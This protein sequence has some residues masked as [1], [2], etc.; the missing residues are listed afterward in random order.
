MRVRVADGP[1]VVYLPQQAP[2]VIGRDTE[3]GIAVS[4]PLVSRRHARLVFDGSWVIEDVGSTNG[5][6]CGGERLDRHVVAGTVTVGLG[7]PVG[8]ARLTLRVERP[9]AA[10]P[11]L[12]GGGTAHRPQMPRDLILGR[13]PACDLPLQDP[14]VS[15]H[16]AL[17]TRDVQAA[18]IEDLGSTNATL[19]NGESVDRRRLRDGDRLLIGNTHL[20][21]ES[22]TVVPTEGEGFVVD[23][24][25]TVIRGGRR[26]VDAVSFSIT[27]PSLV[28]VIGPSGAGKSSLMRLVTGQAAPSSGTV[29]LDGATMTS[30]RHAHQGQ[31]GFVPQHTVAH[32]AL[33]TAQALLYTARLRLA[34][35]ISRSERHRLVARVMEQLGLTA[36]ASTRIS[37]LSGGQQR[38]V[39]IAMEMLTDPSMLILDEPTAGLDPSLVKQ[40]MTVLRHLA[41]SGRQVL[42]VTHDLGHLDLVDKVLVLRAGGRG[43]YFGRP[44]GV[45]AHF[46]TSSWPETFEKLEV[47]DPAAAPEGRAPGSR[48]GQALE[49]PAPGKSG[50]VI[51]AQ[52]LV[53]LRRHCRLIATD[54]LYLTLLFVMP[55]ALGALAL[56]VPG[57]A[58]LGPPR[59]PTS[60]EATRILVLLIVGGAFLGIA[61]PVRDLVGERETYV[62][63]REAGLSS[64]SYLAAKTFVF[65]ALSV[66][67]CS[68]LVGLVLLFKPAPSD[69]LVLPSPGLEVGLAVL[70]TALSGVA[71]GL[72]IS[73]RVATTEQTMP[74]LVLAVMSQLVMCGGLFPVDGR[75]PLAVASWLFPTR[76]TYAAAGATADLNHL[77]PGSDSDRL[78]QHEPRMWLGAMLLVTVLTACWLGIAALGLRRRRP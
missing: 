65:A 40:I 71:L 21:Y 60:S 69:A 17:I 62:H 3:D 4:E 38:R 44:D 20:R 36:H 13:D 59:D 54:P 52:L 45:F 12:V 1:E 28:A 75:G 47:P 77:T 33:T 9:A 11:D 39:G 72:A 30:H 63:E 24:A 46:G 50:Q 53:V 2:I 8:G 32:P 58:G 41:D 34:A 70:F 68:L 61:S 73:S 15:W 31:V 27:R 6:W 7:S 35:D 66:L 74:P 76:W 18:W 48:V 42:V 14:M 43:A 23:R 64:G 29:T 49:L 16:H 10:V 26:I 78:W 25:T 57:S 56:L 51:T 67:Q 22:G 19:V 5:T 37:L 55:L